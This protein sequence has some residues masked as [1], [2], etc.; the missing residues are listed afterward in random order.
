MFIFLD[1]VQFPRRGWV[2]RNQLLS[3]QG[4]KA[5][6]TLPLQKG[7]RNTTMIKDLCF[8]DDAQ[9]T[10]L[11]Q[12]DSFP[13]L[14][15]MKADQPELFSLISDLG[16]DATEYLIKTAIY[17]ARK[18]GI[19]KPFIRSSTLNVS[20]DL[21]AQDRIIAIAKAV[22]ATEYINLAGGV[23]LYDPSAFSKNGLN[24]HFLPQYE[25]SYLSMLERLIHE[26][27]EQVSEEIMNGI[28]L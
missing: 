14:R 8:L 27:P 11:K 4:E 10:L 16:D 26:Q 3:Q 12:L 1:C 6:L 18:L 20:R 17:T 21:K 2:H 7:D 28:S 25:G 19:N 13:A 15:T 23:D 9:D 24:L 22:D 5:W